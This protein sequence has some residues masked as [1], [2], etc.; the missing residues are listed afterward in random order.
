MNLHEEAVVLV[1]VLT[2]LMTVVFQ[3]LV[4]DD[5]AHDGKK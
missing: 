2:M 4:A 5:D 3:I 1:V